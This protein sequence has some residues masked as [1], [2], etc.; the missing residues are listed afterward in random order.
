MM[1]GLCWAGRINHIYSGGIFSLCFPYFVWPIVV[2]R[3]DDK[4]DA[5]DAREHCPLIA[6]PYNYYLYIDIIVII[7]RIGMEC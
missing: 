2:S 4:N 3:R 6:M 1:I 5:R 7:K